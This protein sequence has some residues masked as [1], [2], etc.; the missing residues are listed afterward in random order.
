MFG[1]LR[2]SFKQDPER[3]TQ[4]CLCFGGDGWQA[5]ARDSLPA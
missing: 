3:R 4:K 1:W 2:P 5:L